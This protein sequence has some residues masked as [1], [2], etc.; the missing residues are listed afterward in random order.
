MFRGATSVSLDSKGRLAVP[1]RYRTEILEQNGGQM[2]CTVDIRQPCLLLY[3]LN[4]WEIIEQKLAALSNFD[5]QQRRLQRVMLGYAAEC[6]LDKNGR[7]LLSP[8]L[9]EHVKLDKNI[10][11]VGQLN[12]FE[13]WSEEAWLAQIA[14]D[15]EIGSSGAFVDSEVLKTLSL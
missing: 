14:E 12:K 10:M 6:G 4:E 2:V 15:I 3:P 7:I 11:L 9:R 8:V 1:T 5:P 13:I